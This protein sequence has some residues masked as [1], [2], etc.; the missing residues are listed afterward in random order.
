MYQYYCH[1]LPAAGE[2]AYPLWHGLAPDN[3][4]TRKE[5]VARINSCTGAD[6]EASRRTADQ[7]QR[8]DNILRVVR[9]PERTF[10]S[11]ME[12]ATL[13]FHDL[14]DRQ[15][16]GLNPFS[17]QGVVYRG[18]DD[19]AALNRG[20]ER[21][22]ATQAGV[23]ALS[24]DADLSG[25]LTVPTLTLHAEDDPTAFVELESAFREVVRKAGAEALLVQTFTDEH[26]HSKEATPE[27]AAL[28][29]GMISW[30]EQGTRPTTVSLAAACEQ[31]R[32]AYGEACHFDPA[33]SPAPLATRVYPRVKPEPSV[34][35]RR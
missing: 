22:A 32:A 7:Q 30:I 26:E 5:V 27:Y 19:D 14:V 15:L 33:F 13:T 23:D 10:V 25:R 16:Q 11:H 18:S 31:A 4:L 17:N 12:W 28:F 34:A 21:F 3:V 29:R 24:A 20:V 2:A 8:L 6:L 35:A 9:I 1:N